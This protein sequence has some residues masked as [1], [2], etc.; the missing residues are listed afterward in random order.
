[1]TL[2]GIVGGDCISC[3]LGGGCCTSGALMGIDGV[4]DFGMNGAEGFGD[5]EMNDAEDSGD[6]GMNDAEDSGDSVQN[7]ADSD[8]ADEDFGDYAYVL[9]DD[10][11]SVIESAVNNDAELN[12]GSEVIASCALVLLEIASG[13]DAPGTDKDQAYGS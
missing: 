2:L 11:P 10:V 8:D 5:F 1:M 7:D 4:G 12:D 13:P 9:T 6:F 3:F